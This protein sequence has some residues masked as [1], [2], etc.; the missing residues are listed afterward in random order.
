MWGMDSWF[1]LRVPLKLKSQFK[2]KRFTPRRL[3]AVEADNVESDRKSSEYLPYR[4]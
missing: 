4:D 3:T 1:N 2:N